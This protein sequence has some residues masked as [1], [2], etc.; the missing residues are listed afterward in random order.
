MAKPSSPYPGSRRASRGIL[1][2]LGLP[3]AA[4]AYIEDVL[5]WLALA[6]LILAL[7]MGAYLMAP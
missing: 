2:R 3:P 7:H 4:V 5:G 1:A 6:A